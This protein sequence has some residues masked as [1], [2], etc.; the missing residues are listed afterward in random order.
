MYFDTPR[1]Y[2][3]G[4]YEELLYGDQPLGWDI[5][6]RKETVR[7]ATRETFLDYLDRWYQPGA[8]GRRPRRPP[9]RRPCSSSVEQLLGDLAAQNGGAAGPAPALARR[10]AAV[11]V[12]TKTV[13]PGAPLPRRPEHPADAP[14][15]LHAPAARDGA[16][17]RHVVAPLH[18]GARAARPRLLRL[19]AQP[20]L[21]R[22]RLAV[23]AGG[24]RHQPHRRGG[25]DDRDRAEADR[26]GARAGRRAREGAQLRQGPLRAPAREPAGDDHV[27]PAARGARGPRDRAAGGARRARRGHRRGR[28]SGSRR[29]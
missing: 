17:R 9:R 4:V 14:R 7:A 1:D 25:D 12:H 8:D 29:S 28:S 23:R 26:G 21:H 5:I 16:R 22:H 27:R 6:G 11:K 18:R 19:R 24:R 2:I 20:Q 3:G 15:P 10:A 13:R